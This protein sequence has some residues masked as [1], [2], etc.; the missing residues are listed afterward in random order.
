EPNAQADIPA[1]LCTNAIADVEPALGKTRHPTNCSANVVVEIT[2]LSR[3]VAGK[4]GAP[5]SLVAGS[6]Y[7]RKV[8]LF[9]HSVFQTAAG[10]A[11]QNALDSR[12]W[13][14]SGQPGLSGAHDANAGDIGGEQPGN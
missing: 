13:R 14:G 1:I 6:P 4:A 11:G 3:R 12:H 10:R 5:L 7:G 2:V 9:T 8:R